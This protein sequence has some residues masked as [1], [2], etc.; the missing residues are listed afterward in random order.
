M[1]S[2]SRSGPT[3]AIAT[4]TASTTTAVPATA[5]VPTTV[6]GRALA[7]GAL[8]L[9]VLVSTTAGTAHADT[10]ATGSGGQRLTVSKSTGVSRSGETVTVSGTGYDTS[11][12]IYVSFCVDNGAGAVPS[13]CG[14]GADMSGTSGSSHWISSNPP[15]Y[16]EGLAVPY[17]SGGSFQVRVPVVTTIGDVDCTVRVCSVVSRADHTR[18]SDR[19]QDVRIPIRFAPVAAPPTAPT[20][21]STRPPATSGPAPATTRATAGSGGTANSGAA[22]GPA[23]AGTTGPAPAPAVD[24]TTG[25]DA[26]G[27]DAGQGDDDTV[28]TSTNDLAVTRVSSVGSAGQW[29]SSTLI[30]LALGVIALVGLS[31]ARRRRAS[32]SRP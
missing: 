18:T 31:A 10:T 26:T 22:A 15:A 8:V 23:D 16:G 1:S 4:A 7:I 32:G 17:G 20:A 25:S 14:G 30:L 19:S 29:W 21:T 27:T 6:A 5:T 13:P 24:G 2:P 12:G 3:R 9:G 28:Q 11:K